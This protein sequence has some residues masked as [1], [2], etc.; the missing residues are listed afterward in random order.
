MN[1]RIAHARPTPMR[2]TR[3][4]PALAMLIAVTLAVPDARASDPALT[5]TRLVLGDGTVLPGS[6]PFPVVSGSPLRLVYGPSGW[7][8][9]LTMQGFVEQVVSE[10]GFGV[11][12]G[13]V[14]PGGEVVDEVFLYHDGGEGGR[15]V[16][17]IFLDPTRDQAIVL[18]DKVVLVEGDVLDVPDFEA[19]TIWADLYGLELE[20]P[21]HLLLLGRV[22]EPSNPGVLLDALVRFG[23]DGDDELT[24]A[25][26]LA[27]V[28]DII[29]GRTIDKLAFSSDFTFSHNTAGQLIHTVRFDAAGGGIGPSAVVLDGVV[30]AEHDQLSLLPGLRWIVSV[31]DRVELN[32]QGDWTYL[33]DINGGH[34]VEWDALVHNG[35][36]VAYETGPV[37]GV[38]GAVIERIHPPRLADDGTLFM[39]LEWDSG[40]TVPHRG[41]FVDGELR[42][43]TDATFIEGNPLGNVHTNAGTFDIHPDGS[44]FLFIG[45]A[46]CCAGWGAY[47][48]ATGP[49]ELAGPG[50]AGTG[51]VTPTLFVTGSLEGDS[52][53]RLELERALPGATTHLVVGASA[54]GLPFYGGV[55]CPAP[56]LL[57]LGLPVD[58]DGELTLAGDFPAGAPAGLSLFLQF[59]TD[60]AGGP[61]GYSASNCVAGTTP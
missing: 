3:T 49:W 52:P 29:D 18:D 19:G 10:N 28:H 17:S 22:E 25:E 42:V 45:S 32:E 55:L 47:E 13:Q 31:G 58:A 7:V 30:L 35:V 24:G 41:F 53:V 48:V 51:G 61:F 27:S 6:S 59:W 56:D 38:P 34:N 20:G 57:L 14:L 11:H 54:L 40:F 37:P 36:L 26:V 46:A 60:D 5:P 50:L 4:L 23:I 21:D 2:P 44:R 39:L 16:S 12:E 33:V 15:I 9:D 43:R 1:D 8:M